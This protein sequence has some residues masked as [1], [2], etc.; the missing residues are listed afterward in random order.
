MT[1]IEKLRTIAA[2]RALQRKIYAEMS[3]ITDEEMRD[4]DL[5][6][7]KIAQM[8]REQALAA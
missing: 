3:S 8:S 6:P 2:R 1:L 5:S 4:L 7:A